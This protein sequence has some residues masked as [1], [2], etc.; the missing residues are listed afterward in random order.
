VVLNSDN[1]RF[2]LADSS[3]RVSDL[4]PTADKGNPDVQG[5]VR[6]VLS[7]PE[8]AG[9][10]LHDDDTDSGYMGAVHDLVRDWTLCLQCL[11]N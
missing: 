5:A 2:R 9:Q 1:R 3:T 10:H 11:R 4:A 6:A 7:L 8:R